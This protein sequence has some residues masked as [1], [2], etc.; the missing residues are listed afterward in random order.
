MKFSMQTEGG[1][2]FAQNLNK[3]S[4]AVRRKTLFRILRLA[5]E[6]LR[7]R[8]GALAPRAPG[9]PDMADSMV[10]SIARRIGDVAGGRWQAADEFQAAV[11][12]GPSKNI[13]YALFQEYGTVHHGAQPFGRPAFDT[14]AGESLQI[15]QAEIWAALEA[16]VD[17]S[18]TPASGGSEDGGL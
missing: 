8:M 9:A 11:A 17:R 3:L 15:I 10:I 6:P 18:G 16:A 2:E 13:F 5:A 1:A 4:L 12:V 14:T 7:V